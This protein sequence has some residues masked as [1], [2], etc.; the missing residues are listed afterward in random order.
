M[1]IIQICNLLNAGNLQMAKGIKNKRNIGLCSGYI[2][3]RKKIRSPYSLLSTF[4][5]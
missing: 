4:K 2:R 3:A 5:H 1:L